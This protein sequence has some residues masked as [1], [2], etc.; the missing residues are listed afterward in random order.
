MKSLFMGE[1]ERVTYR[2]GREYLPEVIVKTTEK[3]SSEVIH[4][5]SDSQ[6]TFNLNEKVHLKDIGDVI[7]KDI[8]RYVTGEIIYD[9]DYVIKVIEDEITDQ[10]LNEAKTEYEEF[11]KKREEI[12]GKMERN[13]LSKLEKESNKSWIGRL[14][15]R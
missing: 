9:T 10:R 1:V 15:N 4:E 11:M 14:L 12:W 8:R 2:F 7:I 6:I 5:L 3:V 13:H